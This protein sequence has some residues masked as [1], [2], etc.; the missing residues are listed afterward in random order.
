MS[1]IFWRILIIGI[2]LG[3]VIIPN[4]DTIHSYLLKTS[5]SDVN[6]SYPIVPLLFNESNR[7][8]E[9]CRVLGDHIKV[10]CFGSENT[11]YK[12]DSGITCKIYY[13]VCD[14]GPCP[15]IKQEEHDYYEI[16]F[17]GK[18]IKLPKQYLLVLM[19][20]IV[21]LIRMIEE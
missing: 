6:S 13:E 9:K 14:L 15:I 10:R 18:I 11:N 19:I 1:I 20:C 2:I 12:I 7:T 5:S 8:C 16:N 17:N 3:C 21:I 4:I